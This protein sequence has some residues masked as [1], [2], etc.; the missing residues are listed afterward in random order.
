MKKI[1]ILCCLLFVSLTGNSKQQ[2][3]IVSVDD[4]ELC[5]LIDWGFRFV[6]SYKK[7]LDEQINPI[8]EVFKTEDKTVVTFIYKKIETSDLKW[9]NSCYL[10]CGSHNI[11]LRRS[12]GVD[13]VILDSVDCNPDDR[14]LYYGCSLS[15]EK[16]NGKCRVIGFWTPWGF[17]EEKDFRVKNDTCFS[18]TKNDVWP[19]EKDSSIKYLDYEDSKI[20][21]GK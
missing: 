19:F 7:E 13:L 5:D 12:S 16:H 8:C 4:S 6:S 1:I 9:Y 2:V 14:D 10:K 18:F 20:Y 3:H 15:F 17:G 21:I 11:F